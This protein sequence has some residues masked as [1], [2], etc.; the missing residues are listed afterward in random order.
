[1]T[2]RTPLV[3]AVCELMTRYDPRGL[4]EIGAPRDEYEPEAVDIAALLLATG[5]ITLDQFMT[6][7]HHWFGDHPSD[8][9]SDAAEIVAELQTLDLSGLPK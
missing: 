5:T 8:R 2:R 6:I 1:M 3:L 4:I 9:P 7:W